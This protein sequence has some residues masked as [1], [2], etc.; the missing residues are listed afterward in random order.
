MIPWTEALQAS[1][2][3]TISWS[4]LQLMSIESVM[5]SNHF[6]LCHSLLLQP[7]VF[8]SIKVFSHQGQFFTSGGQSIGVSSLASDLPINNQGNQLFSCSVQFSHL[9]LSDS[10]QPHGLQHARP[11]CPSPTPGACSNSYPLSQWCHPT[12]SAS[13]VPFSSCLQSSQHQGLFQ[14]VSSS[15]QMAKA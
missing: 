7:S 11:L 15:Y 5:P 6:L 10:L 12:L 3:L 8:P 9:V 13:V 14:W 1:L 4:L 2:S